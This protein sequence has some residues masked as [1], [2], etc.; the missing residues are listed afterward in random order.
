MLSEE[1]IEKAKENLTFFNEGDYITR[2]MDRSADVIEEY[3]SRLES[4]VKAKEMEHEYDVNMID[5]V[6]GEAVKLYEKIR[7]L[8][9]ENKTLTHTKKSYKGMLNKQN[10]M[11]DEMIN[12][13]LKIS[14]RELS[15]LNREKVKQ[16]F[17]EKV[18][19]K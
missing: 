11:I 10:K 17:E 14:N 5:E 6:K 4:K 16:Y 9:Q 1:E 18:E 3:V 12:F 2:E 13:I 19:G 7:Q 8:E 15:E